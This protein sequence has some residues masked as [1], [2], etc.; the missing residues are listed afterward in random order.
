MQPLRGAL[1]AAP[2]GLRFAV[3]PCLCLTRLDCA[4]AGGCVLAPCCGTGAHAWILRCPLLL[5]WPPAYLPA[6]PGYS[7]WPTHILCF[8]LLSPRVLALLEESEFVVY[9]AVCSRG[10]QCRRRPSRA[11]ACAFRSRFMSPPASSTGTGAG[12]S[13]ASLAFVHRGIHGLLFL[14]RYDAW[15]GRAG[16]SGAGQ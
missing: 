8:C 1:D 15:P 2:L 13:P 11:C 3:A 9:I 5:A 16:R 6:F 4:V 14:C 7:H 12:L 10:F